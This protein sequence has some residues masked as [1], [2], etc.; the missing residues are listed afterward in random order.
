M[1]KVSVIVPVYN[2]E[3]YLKRCLDSLVN[4][5]LSDIEIIIVDDKSPDNSNVI[6]KEYEKKYKDKIKVFHNKTNKGIGYSRNFGI[7]KASGEYLTFVDSDDFVDINIYE[8]MYNKAKRSNLE[9]VF[10]DIKKIDD[11]EKIIGYETTDDFKDSRVKDNPNIL[12]GINLGPVNKLFLRNLFDDN[13]LFSEKLKYEDLFVMPK[14]ITRAKKIG[15]VKGV[16]YNYIIHQGSQ[17]T[18]MNNKVFDILKVME[19]VNLDLKK[20][21]Y[22]DEIYSYVEYLNMRTIF[23]YTLQQKYQKDKKIRNDFIDKAFDYL[24]KEFPRWKKNKIW[25]QKRNFIKRYIEGNKL[26]TKTYCFFNIIYATR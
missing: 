22:Y 18:T 12:L 24:N 9:L 6:L 8:K 26:L 11:K 2:S 14:L 10:C 20:L 4:Q 16:Y 25:K 7:K 23:R 1:K 15:K 5:T 13:T 17:T 3:K 21:D 19:R